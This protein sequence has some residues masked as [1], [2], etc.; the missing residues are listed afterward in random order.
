MKV[1]YIALSVPVFFILIGIEL[2]WSFYKKLNYYRLNDSISNLSQG[3]GQQL[4][5]IFMKT[6]LFFGYKYIFEN[7][8]AFD[9]P[10]SIWIWILLFI[11][12]DFFYYWFHRMSH[13]VN[14]LWAAH[15]VHHQSEEYNLTV[16]LRQSWFQGWFSWVFYLPLAFVGFDPIMFLTLSSFNTLYQFWI[17]TRAIKSMGPLEWILNTPSHHRVHHGSNPKY[18]DKNHAG[19]LII[20][21]RIFGT[22]QQEEEQVY[23]GITTPLASWNPL[24]ANIHYWDELLKTARQSPRW[25]DKINVFLK[26]PGWFP[27]HLGGFKYAPEIDPLQYRKYDPEFHQPLTGYVI[28]QFLVGLIAGSA[29]LFLNSSI[30]MPALIAGA[31]F[32]ILTLLTC[33]ALLEEKKW[34]VKF[35]YGRLVLGILIVL[36]LDFP[37][38]YQVIFSILNICS[39]IWFYNLHKKNVN[40]EEIPEV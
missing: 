20:W 15:I 40:A 25:Q 10:Q 2:A 39:V 12:V 7:W 31:V 11:G 22:F 18:I 17:H 19:T 33:G 8:R 23:Y 5:G 36:L 28:V 37:I 27:A 34:K 14:A 4:T 30:P 35:E 6:A 21:D 38:G 13:Q 3:I 32:V 9:L 24:W 1:D 29:M 26:P 16:A